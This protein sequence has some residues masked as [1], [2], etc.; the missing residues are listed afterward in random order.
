MAN[1]F[2]FGGNNG[3]NDFLGNRFSKFYDWEV[4]EGE[5]T[6]SRNMF[7][8]FIGLM[9]IWGFVIDIII[10]AALYNYMPQVVNN[11]PLMLGICIGG[12]VVMIIGII[13]NVKSDNPIVSFI[14]YTVC[15]IPM[16]IIV[17]TIIYRYEVGSVVM[18]FLVTLIVSL[19]M[20]IIAT[21]V[22]QFFRGI[23]RGLFI[24]L[25]ISVIADC[26]LVF[27]FGQNLT[28]IDWVLAIIFC[29]YI[30]Y[31]W[32][33]A[34]DRPPTLDNAIDSACALYLDIVNLFVRLLEIFG[35]AK[36]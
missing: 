11:A 2:G 34:Q 3:D 14:G 22:P 19:I 27:V 18:I 1:Q 16:G 21:A 17:A 4:K 10:C 20:T 24:G 12:L 26:V 33:K 13:I 28:V 15:V 30:G 8:L 36:R 25:L 7:N 35:K 23:G 29:G 9:L 5:K 6:Y 31:D 32:V